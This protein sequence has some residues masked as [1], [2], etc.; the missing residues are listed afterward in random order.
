MT[1]QGRGA[2]VRAVHRRMNLPDLLEVLTAAAT[3]TYI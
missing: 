3:R 2:A 1:E